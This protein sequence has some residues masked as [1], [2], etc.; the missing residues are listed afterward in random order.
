MAPEDNQNNQKELKL[1]VAEAIQNDLYRGIVRIDAEAMKE[2]GIRIGDI[3]E[4][5]GKKKTVAIAQLL[6]PQD[7]GLGIIRMDGII[8]KN[9]NATLGGYV[10]VRKANVREAQKVVLAPA[11]KGLY[12]NL[13]QVH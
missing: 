2:L 7:Y 9:A 3:V 6:P 10:T 12:I 1:K 11:T 13:I 4:I 5:E 8:R